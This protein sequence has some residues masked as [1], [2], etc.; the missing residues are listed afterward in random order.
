MEHTTISNILQSVKMEIGT[1][2]E[3]SRYDSW[4][5]LR[6][7]D[8]VRTVNVFETYR[9]QKC[10]LKVERDNWLCL[11]TNYY[12]LGELRANCAIEWNGNTILKQRSF[13][14]Y[15]DGVLDGWG[16]G[17]NTVGCDTGGSYKVVG[18]KIKLMGDFQTVISATLYYDGYNTD[19]Y[20]KFFAPIAFEYA[21]MLKVV[22]IFLGSPMMKGQY[23][24]EMVQRYRSDAKVAFDQIVANSKMEQTNR[25]APQL[26]DI[27]N[28][29]LPDMTNRRR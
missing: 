24:Q 4:L 7:N 18:N 19:I 3:D 28:A 27:S 8:V 22:S 13:V 14:Y 26:R 1:P 25:Q 16:R 21:V 11:P 17:C 2:L 15:D 20:G 29:I 9:Q 12:R 5:M 10:E 23:P 6:I